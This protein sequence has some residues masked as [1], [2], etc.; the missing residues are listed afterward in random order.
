M[1]RPRGRGRDYHDFFLEAGG[2]SADF[3]ATRGSVKSWL[4][5]VVRSSSLDVQKSARV[6]KQA[7]AL[8]DS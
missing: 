6:S 2:H 3:V 7:G 8:D 4:K 5:E 1:S